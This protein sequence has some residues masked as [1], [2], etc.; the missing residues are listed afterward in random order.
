MS[1]EAL[2]QVIERASVNAEFRA[3]LGSDPQRALAGY[4]LTP[5]ERAAL[6][7]GDV[8]R[9]RALGVDLRTSK[10]GGSDADIA[11]QQAAVDWFQGLWR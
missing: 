8:R 5:D 10:W 3:L 11:E 1:A 4:D 9:L 2:G 7:S 6:T